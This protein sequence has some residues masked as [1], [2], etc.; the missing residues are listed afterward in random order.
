MR[1]PK[2]AAILDMADGGGSH[3]V[4]ATKCRHADA[5]ACDPFTD[6]RNVG[7]TQLLR[8]RDRAP[9]LPVHVPDVIE[10][11]PQKQVGGI[12]ARRIVATMTDKHPVR[13][14]AEVE[15]IGHPMSGRAV[16]SAGVNASIPCPGP[17]SS[18]LPALGR[19]S[20]SYIAPE[21]WR[22]GFGHLVPV[23][24]PARHAVMDIGLA[25]TAA[26]TQTNGNATIRVKHWKFLSGEPLG[27]SAPRGA[28]LLPSII[29]PRRI[30]RGHARPLHYTI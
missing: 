11:G 13:N 28:I 9:S 3:S 26:S 6:R 21:Q 29:A 5:S 20:G 10:V 17:A 19:I 8:G 12:H 2:R 23:D 1:Y 15:L 24:K 18:P 27:V 22:N 25:A 30:S 14:R 7:D 4:L 16:A